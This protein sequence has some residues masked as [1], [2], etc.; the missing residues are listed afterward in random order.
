MQ[1]TRQHMDEQGNVCLRPATTGGWLCAECQHWLLT[2]PG[3]SQLNAFDEH[4]R[5]VIVTIS[6]GNR[7]V[8]TT[9]KVIDAKD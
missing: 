1:K 4:G 8:P 7:N 6:K 9:R 2:D 5:R 3:D